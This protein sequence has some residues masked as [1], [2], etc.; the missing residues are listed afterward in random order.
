MGND[1]NHDVRITAAESQKIEGIRLVGAGKHAYTYIIRI[2]LKN[3][4]L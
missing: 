2:S 1:Y 4:L 3:V